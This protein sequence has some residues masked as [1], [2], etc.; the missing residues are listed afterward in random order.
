MRAAGGERVDVEPDNVAGNG[1]QSPQLRSPLASKR[2]F[3]P[4]YRE[5]E[6]FCPACW[7]NK[8][9]LRIAFK[10]GLL[11]ELLREPVRREVLAQRM[12]Y[13]SW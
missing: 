9:S 12:S 4:P 2:L 3:H 1:L 8:A 5:D 6:A 11:D 13:K 10:A 7:I